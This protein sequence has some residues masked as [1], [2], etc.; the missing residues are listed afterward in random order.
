ME[1]SSKILRM[2]KEVKHGRFRIVGEE[3]AA[4]AKGKGVTNPNELDLIKKDAIKQKIYEIGREA[5]HKFL[6]EAFNDSRVS[7]IKSSTHADDM[8][9]GADF[10]VRFMDDCGL[11]PFLFPAQI[12]SSS[13]DVESFR[14]GP[15]YSAANMAMLVINAGPSAKAEDIANQM[16]WE[17]MRLK[18]LF[19]DNPDHAVVLPQDDTCEAPTKL[20]FIRNKDR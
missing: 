4:K 6:L 18:R 20:K 11:P 2:H 7:Y 5:E 10:W 16:N 17:F 8:F 9:I 19:E 14:N 12:K 1:N 15:K 13:K 3:A